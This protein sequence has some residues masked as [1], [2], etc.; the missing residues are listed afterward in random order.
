MSRACES[1]ICAARGTFSSDEDCPGSDDDNHHCVDCGELWWDDKGNY[2]ASCSDYWCPGWQNTFIFLDCQSGEEAS[3]A[4]DDGI[5]PKCF[6]S[7]E[8]LWCKNADCK[9]SQKHEKVLRKWEE[10]RQ[11]GSESGELVLLKGEERWRAATHDYLDRDEIRVF[12]SEKALS[13]F[14]SDIETAIQRIKDEAR[15]KLDQ[16]F[17]VAQNNFYG[18]LKKLGQELQDATK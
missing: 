5:C 4:D 3:F 12:F 18:S 9:C 15:K 17:A 14:V 10:W 13:L 6:L 7:N 8:K 1:E 16:G 2:C 11:H